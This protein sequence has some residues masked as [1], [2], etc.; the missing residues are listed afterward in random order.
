[1]LGSWRSPM[2]GTGAE[3]RWDG[4]WRLVSFSVSESER[5]LRDRA[6]RTPLRVGAALLPGGVYLFPHD[7]TGLPQAEAPEVA[8]HGR[9][10]SC[11]ICSSSRSPFP[12]RTRRWPAR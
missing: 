6:R 1:M 10:T 11:R 2:P 7:N 8:G 9:T 3:T 5:A 12:V 4:R